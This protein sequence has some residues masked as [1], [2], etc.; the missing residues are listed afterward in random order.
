MMCENF[1]KYV[2]GCEVTRE[3]WLEITE[4][5][6][7]VFCRWIT[8][9]APRI[10]TT[11]ISRRSRWHFQSILKWLILAL[12][13][14]ILIFTL[15]A[16]LFTFLSHSSGYHSGPMT[17]HSKTEVITTA[18]LQLPD[19]RH[20]LYSQTPRL[21]CIPPPSS[22]TNSL[23]KIFVENSAFLATNV[24]ALGTLRLGKRTLVAA[25][26]TSQSLEKRKG[27]G[28]R[29]AQASSWQRR[30]TSIWHPGLREGWSLCWPSLFAWV[31]PLW[32]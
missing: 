15:M 24:L 16:L 20:Q 31:V 11:S 12:L 21:E 22:A 14:L 1:N 4:S 18:K 30:Y 17:L 10:P 26:C 6:C 29:C 2:R 3:S 19:I 27:E 8:M 23:L 28:K 25:L 7:V 9:F 32:G 13:C 5:F